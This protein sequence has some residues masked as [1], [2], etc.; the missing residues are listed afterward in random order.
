MDWWTLKQLRAQVMS[1]LQNLIPSGYFENEAKEMKFDP[2]FDNAKHLSAEHRWGYLAGKLGKDLFFE[3]P[4]NMTARQVAASEVLMNLGMLASSEAV[5][6]IARQLSQRATELKIPDGNAGKV[7]KQVE[8]EHIPTFEENI[9]GALTQYLSYLGTDEANPFRSLIETDYDLKPSR[10]RGPGFHKIIEL[11]PNFYG[12]GL[13]LNAA[14]DL[15]SGY[16]ASM[17]RWLGKKG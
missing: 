11:K 16:S 2:S 15:I 6:A 3:G 17:R 13:N 4:A 12:V 9:K 14:I 5:L 1:D 8:T 10:R 7:A